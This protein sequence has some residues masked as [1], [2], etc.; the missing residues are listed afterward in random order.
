MKE[1][2]FCPFFCLWKDPQTQL[3]SHN[4]DTIIWIPTSH[5]P[6]F[7]FWQLHTECVCV[8]VLLQI[9]ILKLQIMKKSWHI[10]PKN[11]KTGPQEVCVKILY[12]IFPFVSHSSKHTAAHSNC[13][14]SAPSV[15]VILAVLKQSLSSSSTSVQ[16]SFCCSLYL[17]QLQEKSL[18]AGCIGTKKQMLT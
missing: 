13:G 18:S 2:L 7:H 11:T 12:F 1:S 3:S 17:N 16:S 9:W 6:L 4:R 8:C 10:I 14:A 15:K 5:P